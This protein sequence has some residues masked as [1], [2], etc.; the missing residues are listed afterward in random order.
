MNKE[1]ILSQVKEEARDEIKKADSKSAILFSLTVA[2]FALLVTYYTNQPS[3]ILI[4]AIIING[5]SLGNLL[6]AVISRLPKGNMF[7][8]H[9]S[10]INDEYTDIN[11]WFISRTKTLSGIAF[12]KHRAINRTIIIFGINTIVIGINVI[13]QF[14]TSQ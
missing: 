10:L 14:I 1:D 12:K 8:D 7:P 11:E 6:M 3:P 2:T 9:L 4:I 13:V 5:L